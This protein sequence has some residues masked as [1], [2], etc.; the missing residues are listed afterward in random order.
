MGVAQ[1]GIE[2]IIF[3]VV[4]AVH[5]VMRKTG[6]SHQVQKIVHGP[7]FCILNVAFCPPRVHLFDQKYTKTVILYNNISKYFQTSQEVIQI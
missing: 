1:I 5:T 2:K 6:V 3:H 4:C 7:H